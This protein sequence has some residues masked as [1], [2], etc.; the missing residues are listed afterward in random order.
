MSRHPGLATARP[1][2][3]GYWR[4]FWLGLLGTVAVNIALYV[5]YLNVASASGA[6]DWLMNLANLG[7]WI[8]NLGALILFAFIRPRVAIGMLVAYGIALGLALLAGIVLFVLCFTGG[9]G[10]P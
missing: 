3:P 5:I 9:A 8:L 2:P 6:P 10:V 7:P 1:R 4:D